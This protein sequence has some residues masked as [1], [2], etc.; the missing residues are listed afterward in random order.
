MRE[1]DC[2]SMYKAAELNWT[3]NCQLSCVG[4]STFVHIFR[5]AVD[6]KFPIHIHIHIHR[7]CVDIQSMDI[8]ISIDAC[9]VSTDCPQSTVGFYCLL[10]LKIYKRKNKML[11]FDETKQYV[12]I[13]CTYMYFLVHVISCQHKKIEKMKQT[14]SQTQSHLVI[15]QVSSCT[16]SSYSSASNLIT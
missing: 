1:I 4:H 10:V 14:K 3:E 13:K 6:M 12:V 8:S 16:S 7:F 2:K 9:P 15:S 11:A 5:V